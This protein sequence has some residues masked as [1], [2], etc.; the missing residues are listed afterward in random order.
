MH[1]L[2]TG[3]GDAL[4]RSLAGWPRI[5]AVHKVRALMERLANDAEI[6]ELVTC[7]GGIQATLP[8]VRTL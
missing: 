3:A 1:P 5:W 7:D 2:L 6:S 4:F 8:R